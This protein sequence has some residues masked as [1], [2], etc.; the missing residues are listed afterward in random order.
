M[1][2]RVKGRPAIDSTLCYIP[3]E[4]SNN[5]SML[6]HGIAQMYQTGKP[7]HPVERTLLTTGALSFLM[8]SASQGHKRLETPMLRVSYKPAGRVILRARKGVVM[9][10]DRVVGSPPK[11]EKIA[12]GF[13]I[14]RGPCIQPRAAICCSATSWRESN[15][16][17]GEREGQRLPGKQQRRERTH[18][19]S[20]GPVAHLRAGPCDSNGKGWKITVLA[21]AFE[22]AR[23]NNPNDLVYAID[24]S[25][26]F[27]VIQPRGSASPE[28]SAA[29]SD[30]PQRRIAGGNSRMH[31]SQR[32][33]SGPE[34]AKAIHCRHRSTQRAG[35]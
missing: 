26:Y 13:G 2:F 33:R 9:A 22:G 27:S 21:A 16:E 10:L 30:H 25:I 1:A 32:R 29:V 24:G 19:R 20:S 5:F 18:I 31:S 15:P 28:K 34:S 23:L 4:N 6:V 3:T 12:T 14:H 8:E 35:I 7:S 11:I 17:M